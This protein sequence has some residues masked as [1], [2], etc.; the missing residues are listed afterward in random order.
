MN[1]RGFNTSNVDTMRDM[2]YGCENLT[3][4]DLSG[5]NTSKVDDMKEIFFCCK[6]LTSL[7]LSG[8]DTSNVINMYKMFRGCSSLTSLDVRSFDTSNV[9][10]MQY[11]FSGCNSLT[12]LDVSSF[13]TSNVTGMQ[14]MFSGC[15]SLT[16]L[17][18]GG[19]DVNSETDIGYMFSDCGSLTSLDLSGLDLSKIYI[20]PNS[21]FDGCK[22]LTA[23]NTPLNLKLPITL[24]GESTDIWYQIDGTIITELPPN[25]NYSIVI[26]KNEI[27]VITSAITVT[28]TKTNYV[29]GDIVNTDDL[30]VTHYD[31][32]GAGAKVTEGYS[33]NVDEIDM[34]TPGIKI[35]KIMYNELTAIVRL[36]V[37]RSV[38]GKFGDIIWSID[39]YGKLT[40]EGTGDFSND[41]DYKRAPWFGYKSDIISAEVNVTGM[42]NAS[43]MFAG[44]EYIASINLEKFDTSNVTDMS[45]M[46]YDCARLRSLDVS[47]F[48][49][50]NVTDMHLMF[51]GCAR[52]RSLDVS[53][54]D[55]SN[56][57]DMMWMFWGCRSLTNLDVSGF[58]TSNITNM[59]SMFLGCES[60]TS[61]NMS[62]FDMSNT[63][64]VYSIF[65]GCTSLA[66]LHTPYNYLVSEYQ[67][68]VLLPKSESTD[69]W[70]DEDGNE[71]VELPQNIN[72]SLLLTKKKVPVSEEIV[73]NAENVIITLSD[74]YNYVYNGQPKTPEVTVT[75]TVS[76][77]TIS[78]NTVSG[79]SADKK[80]IALEQETDYTVTYENNI[81]AFENVTD[82]D[83]SANAPKV[84]ITG[85]NKY[86]GTVSK[87]FFIQKA[88]A[89][90][91]EEQII[92][93]KDYTVAHEGCTLD[94]SGFF[95]DYND[96][97]G[98]TA[99]NH[100]ED[101][102]IDGSVLSGNV[103]VD[104]KGILTYGTGAG[105]SGD[106]A[107]IPV[108][109][110][111]SNH[112]DALINIKIV[113]DKDNGNIQIEN[114]SVPTASPESGRQLTAGSEVTLSCET[115]GAG[116]YYT[117]SG[118]RE[119]LTDPDE[120]STK[121]TDP[122]IIN[123]EVYIR[124]FAV[125]DTNRSKYINLHYTV[126]DSNDKVLKPYAVPGQS[127]IEKG[128]KVELKCDTPDAVIYYTTGGNADMLG[129]VPVDDEHKYTEPIEINK[130]MAIK[131]FAKKEGMKDSGNSTFIYKINIAI[132]A[133]SA[134][135][136]SGSVDWGSYISLKADSDVNIYYTMDQTDP[137]TSGS[138]KPYE[139]RIRV[140]SKSGSVIVIRA[141]AEKNGVYSETV[142]FTYIVSERSVRGL[143]VMFAGS[144]EYI[145]TGSAITP[146]IIVTN[147][148]EE[149][150][151]G[152]DYTVRYSN[153]VKVADKNASKAPKITVTGK[154]NL[155]KSKSITFTIE[156]KFIGDEEEVVGGNIV[157]VSGK[158]AAPILFYDGVKLTA[159]DFDNPNSKKKY[160]RNE[161]ITITGKGNFCG[162]REIDV[163]VVNRNDLKKFTVVVDNKALKENP[164]IYDGKEK[165]LDGYFE[166]YDTSDKTSP[167]EEYSDYAVIYPKNN[168][169]AGKVKFTVVGLGEYYGTVTKTY[170]I[171]P[172][173]VKDNGMHVNVNDG[174]RYPF[175]GGN[176]TIPDLTVTCDGDELRLGRD[177]KVTYSNNKK[178]CNDN[179]ATCKISFIG[180]Y[181]GSKALVRKFNITAAVMDDVDKINES[182][183]VAVA[184]MVYTGKP[185]AYK[186]IPYVTVN[187][188]LLKSSD[189]NVSYYK[190]VDRSQVID[191]KTASSSV[192]LTDSDKQTVYMKIEG[193]GNYEGILTAQY[194]VYKL[195]EG[196]IDLSKAK[197]TIVGGNKVEYTGEGVAPD[198]EIKYKSD[199][200]WKT[201]DVDDIGTYITVTY[202]NNVNKGKATVMVNGNG[203]RYVGSK[204]A[205]FN[206][207]SKSMK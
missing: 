142:T 131:A 24:P 153:N 44:C 119:E 115:K 204:T 127:T 160:D 80:S 3:S 58:D 73:L 126:V 22:N 29:C 21:V 19:F 183:S 143:Q 125:K 40:V 167:L 30:V 134:E 190:D 92:Y 138:A 200:G 120:N 13:N 105:K 191:G 64:Y 195:I 101:D 107:V 86:S 76:G 97:I 89:P 146:A 51:S 169:N 57:T 47:G 110:S 66:T 186:S 23:I 136:A 55:T 163:K 140:D 124:A 182:V 16:S 34:S 79:N 4:L 108:M 69:I 81:N 172:R 93:I 114:V 1:L 174:D 94:L 68:P 185:G 202:I 52:L 41:N 15:S 2:F 10:N 35:L 192:D 96:K 78:G 49:T 137:A 173:V 199:S 17:N 180:N 135:P 90:E 189:Y 95:A 65:N 31:A 12:S 18:V 132:N 71:Y 6:S 139:G 67:Y 149:L 59:D 151:E 38:D 157:V 179:K 159:K 42:T 129:A 205:T 184:D 62:S 144:D 150:V 56:V 63:K 53:S 165:T 201:I 118:N 147:N 161:T 70:T 117:I 11:M 187:G 45:S 196:T 164:L 102:T 87:A 28:K 99:G 103:S 133:P 166:V 26:R 46:F 60:L 84:I 75:Y 122:I 128:T 100:V 54:F 5:F 207:V 72:H 193:K 152:E 154:G 176:V 162:E 198:I 171:K 14:Y 39:E 121:Y 168:I 206:V 98:Y 141:V 155:T 158:T 20:M 177:Y 104:D 123:S 148:G 83:T 27:P 37:R 112:K 203:D 113:L 197:V 48:D 77:N 130:D 7:D 170:T 25:L 194:D 91:V 188:V 178:I 85:Q 61:L 50:S 181:K 88:A 145:Y 116:I 8:F 74:N 109:V 111:F 33:T 106:F 156:P 82:T 9:T 32:D 175:T 36:N 43:C